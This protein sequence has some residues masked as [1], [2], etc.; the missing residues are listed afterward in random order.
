MK[1]IKK[2]SLIVF[3]CM[4]VFTSCAKE[5]TIVN[6]TGTNPFVGQYN[7][8]TLSGLRGNGLMII[9]DEGDFNFNF[10]TEISQE[11]T[12]L[13]IKG[14]VKWNSIVEATVKQDT[15]IFGSLTGEIYNGI[16]SGYLIGN[17]VC[18]WKAD[19]IQ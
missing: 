1:E 12:I 7:F 18:F 13:I 15:T 17:E 6:P 8:R 19:Y 3:F 10:R 9:D 2:F 4:L 14:R 5:D 11:P 16:G